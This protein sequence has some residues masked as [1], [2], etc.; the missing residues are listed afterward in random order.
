MSEVRKI[1]LILPCN[2][3]CKRC[4]LMS[5]IT[6]V[7]YLTHDRMLMSYSDFIFI[8]IWKNYKWSVRERQ[9]L[10]ILDHSPYAFT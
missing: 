2:I 7:H 10:Q 9:I 5:A 3:V 6:V 8:H 1:V 4:D